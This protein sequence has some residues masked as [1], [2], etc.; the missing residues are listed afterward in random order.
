MSS[1][2]GQAGILRRHTGFLATNLYYHICTGAR[3]TSYRLL[4][5]RAMAEARPTLTLSLTDVCRLTP[6]CSSPGL[7]FCLPPARLRRQPQ[8]TWNHQCQ[9]QRRG[10]FTWRGA[11]VVESGTQQV[12]ATGDD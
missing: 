1:T 5:S 8:Q 11:P 12:V 6:C 2:T 3:V 7:V 4:A 9:A 10:Q